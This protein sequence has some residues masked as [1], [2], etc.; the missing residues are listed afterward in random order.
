MLFSRAEAASVP[1]TG[2]VLVVRDNGC[3]F[4]QGRRLCWSWEAE[5]VLVLG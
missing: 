4:F 1:R 3:A 5:I 2:V